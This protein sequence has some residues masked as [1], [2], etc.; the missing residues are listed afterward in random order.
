MLLVH[1]IMPQ[2]KAW[3]YNPGQRRVRLAPNVGYDNPAIGTDNQQTNDQVNVFNGAMDRYN[4]K[5]VGK[6]EFYIPYNSVKMNDR[7]KKY[8]EIIKK[9]HV[10]QDLARYELHRVWVIEADLKPGLNHQF[11][12][13]R[14]YMDEDSWSIAAVDLYDN[15]DQLYKFQEAHLLTVPWVSTVTGSPELIYDFQSGRYF[16]T[17]LSNEDKLSDTSITFPDSYFL[18]SQ[19]AKRAKK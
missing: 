18:D 10:N 5:L 13:R 1:E 17:A 16:A 11:K 2:R 19:L 14:F 3:L 9:G 7:S 4:W 15:R 6:K 8:P 12:K